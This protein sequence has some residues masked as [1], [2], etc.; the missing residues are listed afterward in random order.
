MANRY[1]VASTAGNWSDTANWSATS[2]GSGGAS[3]PGPGDT[4]YFDGNGLG[5]CTLDV[6]INVSSLRIGSGYGTSVLTATHN[7]PH[8]VSGDMIF[9]RGGANLL[10]STWTI[11][12]DLKTAGAR[13]G[14]GW[15]ADSST[16]T[17]TGTSLLLLD[18]NVNLFGNVELAPGAY[19]T[20]DTLWP[21]SGIWLTENKWL[22][23]RKNATLYIKHGESQIDRGTIAGTGLYIEPG[24]ALS[25]AADK[26]FTV[27]MYHLQYGGI[28]QMDGTIDIPKLIWCPYRGYVV[29][30][31]YDSA[32]VQLW[33]WGSARLNLEPGDYVFTG[34]F[35]T[36]DG[37]MDFNYYS[38]DVNLEFRGDVRINFTTLTWRKGAGTITLSGA[39]D[40]DID[41]NGAAVEDI[42]V[43]KTAGT[44][45]FTGPVTTDS[46]EA[47]GASDDSVL[48]FNGQEIKTVGDF[49]LGP[50][51]QV[52]AV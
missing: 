26:Q 50:N 13:Y 5:N 52:V 48:D 9:D 34:D 38:N 11:G 16:I 20:V 30:A 14:G 3:V 18:Y 15:A 23:I 10:T 49:T 17:F 35:T 29:P 22:K 36:S 1:W 31:R 19:V 41:F 21:R 7:G 4:A 42:V 47:G 37:T 8:A 51:T 24:G 33:A 25:G 32:T 45:T 46:F 39:N 27:H 43:E 12:G 40:Q 2:G 6:A 28:Q 44:V